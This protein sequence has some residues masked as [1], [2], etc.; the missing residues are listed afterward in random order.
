MALPAQPGY[1]IAALVVGLA[2]MLGYAAAQIAEPHGAFEFAYLP[3]VPGPN[4]YDAMSGFTYEQLWGHVR[5]ICLLGPGL[6][7]FVWGLQHYVRLC[8]PRDWAVLTWLAVGACL[9]VT[10]WRLVP[11]SSCSVPAS[12]VDVRSRG[13]SFIRKAAVICGSTPCAGGRNV[14]SHCP[15]PLIEGQNDFRGR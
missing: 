10:G 9:V 1:R 4:L 12:T 7:L 8:P 13:K 14:G 3:S 11:F 6:V 15:M 5:R 2:A